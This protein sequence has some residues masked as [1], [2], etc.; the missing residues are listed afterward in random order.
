MRDGHR[1]STRR[2]VK[3][4]Y[5]IEFP[6]CQL[7]L[8]DLKNIYILLKI[9]LYLVLLF[10]QMLTGY[11][12]NQSEAGM[13]GAILIYEITTQLGDCWQESNLV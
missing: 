6:K 1:Y 5:I 3:K 8:P 4:L 10:M 9:Y 12:F 7:L 2:C 13:G 11:R